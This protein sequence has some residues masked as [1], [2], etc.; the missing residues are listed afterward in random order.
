MKKIILLYFA[1]I[2]VCFFIGGV[3]ALSTY[4]SKWYLF[5]LILPISFGWLPIVYVCKLFSDQLVKSTIFLFLM[6][7]LLVAMFIVGARY[8]DE[9][10]FWGIVYAVGTFASA[11]VTV[12]M[13]L[14]VHNLWII[15]SWWGNLI[16][17]Y[18]NG[19]D[20]F[21]LLKYIIQYY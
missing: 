13:M 10:S 17:R 14:K 19:T 15:R 2:F 4:Y 8:I 7:I 5:L 1:A 9:D 3:V 20:F 16:Y 18:R 21:I 12:F 6:L 11:L